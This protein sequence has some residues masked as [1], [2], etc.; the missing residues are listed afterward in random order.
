MR[1]KHVI[2]IKNEIREIMEIMNPM[3]GM[4]QDMGENQP[5]MGAGIV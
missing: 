3:G 4:N 1:L 2:A 5:A